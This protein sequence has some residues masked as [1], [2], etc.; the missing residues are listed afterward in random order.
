MILKCC[1]I[2][3]L[4][5]RILGS[6]KKILMFGAGVIGQISTPEILNEHGLLEYIDCFIDNSESK[7]GKTI[8]VCGKICE[9]RSPEYIDSCT[10]NSVI[11][12]NVSRFSD[13]LQQLSSMKCTENMECYLMPMMLIHNYCREKSK[14]SPALVSEPVIPKKLHYMWLGKKTIPENL[15][16]CIDSWKKHC[17]DYEIVEWNENNYD[18][19]KHIYMKQAYEAGAYGFVPD[20]ARL[21]ILYNEGGFY[22][23]TDVEIIRSIDELRYQAAF[24]GVEKWQ[25]LNFGGLSGAVKENQMIK[26]FLEAR[27]DIAFYNEDGTQNRNTCGY[28]DTRVAL[29][30]GYKV[31]GETQAI[32]GMNIYA[33]DYFHSYD[34]MSGTINKTEN[35]YSV[36]WFNG[37]WLD[38]KMKEAN[39]KA[40]QEYIKLYTVAI[41]R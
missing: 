13:V 26:A 10:Q 11:L 21:D 22:L 24:C 34:Y 7:W 27:S 29:D 37:G 16:K 18:I 38:D 32:N 14:G 20:F 25:V 41:N 40:K 15:Q 8:S 39:E 6:Q 12:L 30:F 23:D 2:D 36:H 5:K 31:N 17:P 19:G 9:I 1:D 28:Y 33:Y 3:T 4:R 35:T